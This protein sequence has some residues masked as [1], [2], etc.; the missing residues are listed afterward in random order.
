[1]STGSAI[2]PLAFDELADP[3]R[4]A[5]RPRYERLG[6]LGAFFT[7]MAHQPEALGHFDAF[8]ES[9]KRA[10]GPELAEAVALT[11]AT[12]LGNDYER[13][14]H[15]RLAVALGLGADWV[16]A[17]ERLDPDAL[18]GDAV[19]AAAQRFVL[20]ACDGLRAGEGEAPARALDA[21]V[22]ASDDATAAGVALLTGRFIAHAVVSAACRLEPP[23]PSIFAETE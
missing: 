9:L 10:L 3:L 4:E 19:V 18:D 17:V 13:H 22:A 16:A 2:T 15:E 1:M 23:V 14:Q 5:L 20:A 8:T 7:H 11:A 6:Y 21:L 12:R